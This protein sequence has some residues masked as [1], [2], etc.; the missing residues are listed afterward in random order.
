MSSIGWYPAN[1]VM[2]FEAMAGLAHH[3]YSGILTVRIVL[4]GKSSVPEDMLRAVHEVYTPV[5][6]LFTLRLTFPFGSE[7]HNQ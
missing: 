7:E 5:R 4:H 6:E 1:H 3:L 2:K